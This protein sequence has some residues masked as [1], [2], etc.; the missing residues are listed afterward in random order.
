MY[1]DSPNFLTWSACDLG[2]VADEDQS[3]K[4]PDPI[5]RDFGLV[6]DEDQSQFPDL[7][8]LVFDFKL[9]EGVVLFELVFDFEL[10]E[11]VV[12]FEL[13]D[14]PSTFRIDLNSFRLWP[15]VKS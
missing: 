5:C 7:I 12:V 2:L 6:V 4:F 15:L 14:R 10:F 3:N 1:S 9:F 8:E 13:F 11:G